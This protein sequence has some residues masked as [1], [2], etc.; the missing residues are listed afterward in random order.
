RESA[1]IS[2]SRS[3]GVRVSGVDDIF[4]LLFS[5]L[6]VKFLNLVINHHGRVIGKNPVA[7]NHRRMS[8]LIERGRREVIIQTPTDIVLTRP[9]PIRPPRIMYRFGADQMA[10]RVVIPH[11]QESGEPCALFG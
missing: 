3:L 6:R 11:G 2:A 8:H 10:K 4:Y 1:T 5:L 9:A 7:I